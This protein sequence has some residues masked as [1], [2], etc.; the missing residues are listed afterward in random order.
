MTNHQAY[1]AT[2]VTTPELS[3]SYF[4]KPHKVVGMISY[5]SPVYARMK[6]HVSL[7]YNGQSGNR[8]SYM[9]FDSSD[10]NNS[11]GAGG[12]LLYVPTQDELSQMS[13]S[14]DSAAQ[15]AAFEKYISEDKYLSNRR[16]Q[17][18]E[19][20]GGISPFENRFDLHFAQDFYYDRKGGRKIQVVADLITIQDY[21]TFPTM[22]NHAVNSV[23]HIGAT[24][25]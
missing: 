8:F 22:P 19:R 20:F 14:G 10:V 25:Q 5:T 13:W 11:G 2:D 17:F 4:D 12:F 15:A 24:N 18:T 7:V 9:T 16:G 21:S 3:Y 1:V 23:R 6:S